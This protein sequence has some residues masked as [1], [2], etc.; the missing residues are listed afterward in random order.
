MDVYDE[1]IAELNDLKDKMSRAREHFLE[2]A[3]RAAGAVKIS[4]MQN[5]QHAFIHAA[6]DYRKAK[7]ALDRF[8][9]KCEDCA[10]EGPF[11]CPGCGGTGVI[12]PDEK[13]NDG[14]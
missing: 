14:V 12:P 7:R 2:Q 5:G 6:S 13:E 9:S 11:D 4:L 8:K 1:A 10:G 3:L